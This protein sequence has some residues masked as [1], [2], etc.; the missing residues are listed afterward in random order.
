MHGLILP[1]ILAGPHLE[2]PEME[3]LAILDRIQRVWP[4]DQGQQTG[5]HPLVLHISGARLD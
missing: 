3:L 5:P 1:A 2:L 4:A